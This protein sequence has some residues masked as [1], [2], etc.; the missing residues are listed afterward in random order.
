MVKM[1]FSATW[2]EWIM[3]C[4]TFDKYKVLMN[5]QPRENI[6]RDRGLRQGDPLSLFIFILCMEALVSFLN[7]AESK[8]KIIGMR[9]S[10][11]SPRYLTLFLLMIIFSYVSRSPV[12]VN[13]L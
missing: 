12:N 7:H 1:G 10:R 9:V 6:S 3:R 2:I 11:I 4:I 8:E 5:G 13:K